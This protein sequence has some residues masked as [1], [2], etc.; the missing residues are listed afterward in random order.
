MLFL[1]S[2]S[3]QAQESAFSAN[4]QKMALLPGEVNNV[5]IVDGDLY[6]YASGVLL[7]AQ[8][9]GEQLLGFWADTTFVKI[10]EDVQYVIRHPSTG[11]L[12][13]TQLDRQGQSYL[14]CANKASVLADVD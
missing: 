4:H 5:S 2:F 11:D 9:S 12:Y 14:F 1:L 10:A 13:F 8:R 7:L 6:C 3:V